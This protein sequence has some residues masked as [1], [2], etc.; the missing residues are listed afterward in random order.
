MIKRDNQLVSAAQ[1]NKQGENVVAKWDRAS[2][3]P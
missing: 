3:I 1:T 2:L